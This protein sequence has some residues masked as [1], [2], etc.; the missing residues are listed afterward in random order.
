MKL[1]RL[2]LCV[3]LFATSFSASAAWD[4]YKTGLS[5]NGGYYD[6][7]MNTAAP[8]FQNNYFGRYTTSG[9][10]ILNFSELLTYK[11]GASNACGGNLRYRVYRT[12]D[13]P[14]A[15][16]TLALTFCCNQGGT[17][18]GGGACGPDVNNPGD[19]KW[20]G[21]SGANLLTS[22]TLSGTYVIEVYYDATGDDAGGCTNTKYSSNINCFFLNNLQLLIFI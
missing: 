8:D 5:I 3:A 1:S 14:G 11:N 19:Q 22:L 20:K 12:S 15:F 17:D 9:S 6:C 13:T 18:C 10:L 4:I 16:A 2:F 21:N 7:Q